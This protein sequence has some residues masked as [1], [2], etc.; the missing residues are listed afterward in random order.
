MGEWWKPNRRQDLEWSSE[1]KQSG[2]PTNDFIVWRL[3]QS[4]H[5]FK[6][7]V[8]GEKIKVR[9]LEGKKNL[10]N[11]ELRREVESFVVDQSLSDLQK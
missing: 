7:H 3:P 6:M 8:K 2:F 10:V 4:G 11:L 1:E 5:I 9:N